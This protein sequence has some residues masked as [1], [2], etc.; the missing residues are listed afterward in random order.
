[1]IFDFS[2]RL[3]ARRSTI[4]LTDHIKYKVLRLD[5]DLLMSFSSKLLFFLL[6]FNLAKIRSIVTTRY[7]SATTY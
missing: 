2:F 1:M 4:K 7:L 6:K 5:R 3:T